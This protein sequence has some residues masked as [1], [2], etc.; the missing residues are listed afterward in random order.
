MLYCVFLNN[1]L[2]TMF[3]ESID[4]DKICGYWLFIEKQIIKLIN[5]IYDT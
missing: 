5:T 2:I 1:G 4:P 3:N